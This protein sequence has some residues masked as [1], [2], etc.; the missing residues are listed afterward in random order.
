MASVS[1]DNS[2]RIWRTDQMKVQGVIEDIKGQKY[3]K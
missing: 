3:E 2:I 1:H